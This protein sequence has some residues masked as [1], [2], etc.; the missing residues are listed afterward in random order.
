M[1]R[2]LQARSFTTFALLTLLL[3]FP[4]PLFSQDLRELRQSIEKALR[5]GVEAGATVGVV[6]IDGLTGKTLLAGEHADTPLVPAS[7]QKLIT[8]AVALDRFGPDYTLDTSLFVLGGELVVVGGGDPSLGDTALAATHGRSADE[9]IEQFAQALRRAGHQHLPGDLRVID[10]VFDRET[11]HDSWGRFNI[12][13]WYGA[14][15]AGLNW[16]T[17]CVDFT[18]VP[19]P[20]GGEAFVETRPRSAGFRV[21]GKVQTV[22]DVEQHNPILGKRPTP[23]EGQSVYPVGGKVARKAGP[24]SKPVDNPLLFFGEA[25][26]HGLAERG[27]TLG[28]QVRAEY[29][30]PETLGSAAA[31]SVYR[32][33]LRDVLNRVNRNS[34]NMMAEGLAKLNGRD[35]LRARGKASARGSWETG[36]RAAVHFLRGL[37]IDPDAVVAADGS[38]LS[39]ENRTTARVLAELIAAMLR[40]HAHGGAFLDSLAVSGQSGSMRRRVADLPGRVRAKTG[41]IRSVSSLSGVVHGDEGR[42]IVFSVVHNGFEGGAGPYRRQQDAVARAIAAWLDEAAASSL[43][44]PT[45]PAPVERALRAVGAE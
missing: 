33:P 16:N 20:E 2:L 10:A 39:R 32:T 25:L 7:N 12:L 19:D 9:M 44:A 1:R 15:I 3:S 8:T 5:P 41:T 34:Q 40:D 43:A 17:N 27:I 29:G 6:L 21:Q 18:F 22:V 45:V 42:L 23:V 24:Y 36:H 26:R 35:Y 37:G 28:G 4:A 38:G 30:L 31:V 13:Q 14:P 11:V